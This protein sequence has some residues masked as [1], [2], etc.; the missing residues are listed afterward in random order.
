MSFA[1]LAPPLVLLR[2]LGVRDSACGE[3]RTNLLVRL[4]RP[5]IGPL[6]FPRA[7]ARSLAPSCSRA[8]WGRRWLALTRL[9]QHSSSLRPVLSAQDRRKGGD[10]WEDEAGFDPDAPVRSQRVDVEPVAALEA[11]RRCMGDER[12]A[13]V[14]KLGW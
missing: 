12:G 8:P 6:D 14:A 11:A 4:L 9:S 5:A 13:R 3:S 7:L 10:D 1:D 2:P